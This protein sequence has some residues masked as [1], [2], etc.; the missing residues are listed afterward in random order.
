[1]KDSK[2][3]KSCILFFSVECTGQI[4]KRS[5]LIH[6][7]PRFDP[8]GFRTLRWLLQLL[9]LVLKPSG[10]T[11]YPLWL[12]RS[13]N[14]R[15]RNTDCQ[16]RLAFESLGWAIQRVLSGLVNE[17][18]PEGL[19]LKNDADYTTQSRQTSEFQ[20]VKQVFH[21]ELPPV[22]GFVVRGYLQ[23]QMMRWFDLI[24]SPENSQWCISWA[25]SPWKGNKWYEIV[26]FQKTSQVW[27]RFFPVRK[28]CE[29]KGRSW[30]H[31]V[32]RDADTKGWTW[33]HHEEY[34]QH[35][36]GSSK[37]LYILLQ[38]S[39]MLSIVNTWNVYRKD[40][41]NV[42]ARMQHNAT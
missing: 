1:M 11:A 32:R 8:Y 33:T 42:T 12:P 20:G 24:G 41:S 22:L 7:V 35:C 10:Q 34:E 16:G 18:K 25:S 27:L 4:K 30:E 26:D 15:S 39:E 36:E 2:S 6:H 3:W 23:Q 19:I 37:V 21:H 5:P 17:W 14:T 40:L 31:V 38:I 28:K 13:R 9:G 29:E